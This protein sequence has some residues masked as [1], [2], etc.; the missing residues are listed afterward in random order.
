[1]KSNKSTS[2]L[3]LRSNKPP[4]PKNYVNT[5][6][7]TIEYTPSY[8]KKYNMVDKLKTEEDEPQPRYTFDAK[9][10]GHYDNYRPLTKVSSASFRI[11]ALESFKIEQKR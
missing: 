6:T 1:M 10:S 8:Q 2:S 4:L 5:V 7:K 11:D 3:A 9:R